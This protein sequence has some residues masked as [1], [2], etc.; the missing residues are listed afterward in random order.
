MLDLRVFEPVLF[1]ADHLSQVITPPTQS[2]QLDRFFAGWLPK[3]K[4]FRL[5]GK[6]CQHAR[7]YSVRLGR[8]AEIL[9]KI[10]GARSMC[11]VDRQAQFEAAFKN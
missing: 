4:V 7:I 1:G 10:A 6:K 11:A 3:P 2:A 5:C 9:G 8:K